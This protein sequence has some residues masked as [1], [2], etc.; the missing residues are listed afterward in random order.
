MSN[1]AV[2]SSVYSSPKRKRHADEPERSLRLLLS[3]GSALDTDHPH[4]ASSEQDAIVAEDGSPRTAVAG[5]LQ[6]LNIDSTPIALDFG[7]RKL[8]ER[9]PKRLRSQDQDIKGP[10]EI[11]SSADSMSPARQTCEASTD[12]IAVAEPQ[13]TN[14]KE[15]AETPTPSKTARAESP[16]PGIDTKNPGRT[17]PPSM[18]PR[19]SPPPDTSTWRDIEITGH[20]PTDPSD[21]GY[22]INGIGFRPTPAMAQA[23]AQKRTQQ[24]LDWRNREAREARQKR[25]ERRRVNG[26]GVT[27]EGELGKPDQRRRVRF[28]EGQA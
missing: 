27:E 14:E 20:A 18:P 2:K 12:R 17:K 28:Q 6:K 26:R 4:Q 1:Q 22:G 11:R 15:I 25:S 7:E 8:V 5:H 10:D 9:S 16:S 3:P 24:I 21:D 13:G 23:R 19:S